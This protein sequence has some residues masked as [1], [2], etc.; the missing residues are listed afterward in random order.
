[1]SDMQ[2]P[3]PFFREAGA[4]TLIVANHGHRRYSMPS[5]ML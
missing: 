5:K 2:Q 4:L 1:M 3:A